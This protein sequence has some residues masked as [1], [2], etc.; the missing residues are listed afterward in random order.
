[1]FLIVSVCACSLIPPAHIFYPSVT[2]TNMYTNAAVNTNMSA[3]EHKCLY[4]CGHTHTHTSV[5]HPF[6]HTHT[7]F[8]SLPTQR[9][10]KESRPAVLPV[11]RCESGWGMTKSPQPSS[12]SLSLMVIP[13][14]PSPAFTTTVASSTVRR[15][16]TFS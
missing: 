2:H 10:Q 4:P 9:T 7:H 13:W 1:M 12:S 8:S 5:L 16:Y 14:R 6:R 11:W 15:L 3:C